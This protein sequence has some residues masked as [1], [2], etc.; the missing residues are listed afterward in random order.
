MAFFVPPM[1]HFPS[2]SGGLS[3]LERLATI[4]ASEQYTLRNASSDNPDVVLIGEYHQGPAVWYVDE[5]E[6]I[7]TALVE[8]GDTIL[9]E[10]T[11]GKVIYP[12]LNIPDTAISNIT[13]LLAERRVESYFNDSE[14][15]LAEQRIIRKS[16]STL[17]T[18]IQGTRDPLLAQTLARLK[19]KADQR[20]EEVNR[21]REEHFVQGPFGLIRHHG[22]RYQVIGTHHLDSSHL[23]NLL[24]EAALSYAVLMPTK[25]PPA[26]EVNEYLAALAVLET[27]DAPRTEK[28]TAVK[29]LRTHPH[30][31]SFLALQSALHDK[32]GSVRRYATQALSALGNPLSIPHLERMLEDN[33]IITS[34]IAHRSLAHYSGSDSRVADL[35]AGLFF[36]GTRES[37]VKASLLLSQGGYETN[38]QSLERGLSAED[39]Y[40]RSLAVRLCA[41]TTIDDARFVLLLKDPHPAVREE[42]VRALAHRDVSLLPEAEQ[43]TDRFIRSFLERTRRPAPLLQLKNDVDKIQGSL[44]GVFVGDVLGA[45]IESMPL[46]RIRKQFGVVRDYLP[47]RGGKKGIHTDDGDLTLVLMQALTGRLFDPFEI[48]TQFGA[49]GKAIDDDYDNNCGYGM[50]TLMAFRRLYAGVNWRFSGNDSPGCGAAM[51]V[52]ALAALETPDLHAYLDTQAQ[53][54]HANPIARAGAVALGHAIHRAYTLPVGFNRAAFVQEIAET[55]APLSSLL[56]FEISMIPDLL[57]QPT[58]Y[59]LTQFP[60]TSPKA[61]AKGKYT[62][63]TVPAALYCFLKTPTDFEATVVTAVNHSG[64][65]DS[66]GA[67]AGALSGAHN[68]YRNIPQ[69]FIAGLAERDKIDDAFKRF[70]ENV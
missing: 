30:R 45:P 34:W 52:A 59:A 33:D 26:S 57:S 24:G 69:R 68:G 55:A 27:P 54:T 4:A 56:A 2:P 47:H 9:L 3:F 25:I 5:I 51:R 44:Y 35:A 7:L 65:S 10:G 60:H 53:I 6:R 8:S 41:Q 70:I 12:C 17:Y 16:R 29:H 50:K 36:E 1:D 62:Q 38:R 42:A 66:V 32:S 11:E 14:E 67:M 64:D 43:E 13:G 46:S 20:E 22:R 40:I 63:G 37:W 39:P 28:C 19:T 31:S 61:R 21:Q 49:V 23:T 58:E 15:L 48:A 18:K